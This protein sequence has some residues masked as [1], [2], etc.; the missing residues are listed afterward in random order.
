MSAGDLILS[1]TP[2]GVLL[3]LVV[4][5]IRRKLYRQFP[6]F[7]TYVACVPPAAALRLSVMNKPVAYFVAYWVTEAVYGVLALLAI[8]EVFNPAWHLI[9]STRYRWLRFLPAVVVLLIAGIAL[10]RAIYHPPGNSPLARLSA[11]TF[12]FE[13]GV[14][15]AQ[16][17]VFLV[18]LTLSRFRWISF[19]LHD[20]SILSGFGL[21]AMVTLVADLSRSM[22]GR[23]FEQIFR[24]APPVAYIG[25]TIIWLA[26]FCGPG[27]FGIR[28]RYDPRQLQ[29]MAEAL[30]E[31]QGIMEKIRKAFGLR[32]Q[33]ANA[34]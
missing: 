1:L 19:G 3:A 21:A 8:R 15:W 33:V 29:E 17:A 30:K 2:P 18:S 11:G 20:F 12:A 27:T 26:A 7:F 32:H 34:S 4:I 10:W 24:Y 14:R 9:A 22:F 31:Q 13:L 6:I 25:A 28:R 16:V 23:D 5:L